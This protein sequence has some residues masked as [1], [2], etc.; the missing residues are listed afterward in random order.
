MEHKAPIKITLVGSGN[1]GSAIAYI[2]GRNARK[3]DDDFDI[4]VRMWVHEEI[5]NGK[6]LTE[7]INKQHENVKYLPGKKLPS[8]VIAVADLVTA[9]GDS[10]IL[11]FV[12]PHQFVENVCTQLKG[13]LKKGALAISLIKGFLIDKKEGTICLVSETI[14]EL[15]NIDVAV[16]M[17]A[18]VAQDVANEEFA[19]ATIGY[20]G[21]KEMWPI[22]KKL[23]E[24]DNFR[25]NLT[26]D[27][28]TVE[29][30]GGLK[31]IVACAAGFAD[32]LGYGGNT[33]A[34]II[35]LGLL[36]III[37]VEL[38]YHCSNIRTY[39]ESCGIADLITSCTSG[40]NRKICEAFVKTRKSIKDLEREMLNGQSVQ[41]PMTAEAVFIMLKKHDMLSRFP[42]F[43]VV[44][45]I[46]R[47]ELSPSLLIECLRQ[48]EN[49]LPDN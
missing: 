10:D 28:Y 47:K 49:K 5:I 15:L 31:N 18:N 25:I 13:R 30:C 7:I 11:V 41:G 38:F 16:L 36:E 21:R 43:V 12:T 9:C 27:S 24:T 2:V 48:C 32:G 17:G 3:H 34:A 6:K 14:R 29:L 8:N 45:Q 22:L 20:K 42:L 19:E 1:W 46:C 35:R 44:H 23:F 40:R 37:F 4:E 39:F 33:K 26:E